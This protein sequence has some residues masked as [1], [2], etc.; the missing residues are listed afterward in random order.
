MAWILTKYALTAAVVVFV[1]ELAKRSDK[2]G[3]FVAALPLITIL[4]LTCFT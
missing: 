1:S 2:L 4:T 3:A